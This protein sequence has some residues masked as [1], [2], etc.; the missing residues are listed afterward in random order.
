MRYERIRCNTAIAEEG[1]EHEWGASVGKISREM[2]TTG[3]KEEKYV[4]CRRDIYVHIC[5]AA[6]AGSDTRM[7]GCPMPVVINSGSGNQGMTVSIPIVIYANE[8]GISREKMY[9]A[10][11]LSNLIAINQKTKGMW[12]TDKEILQI[13]LGH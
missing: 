1:L 13:M 5:S 8:M 12:G 10:L 7:N 3:K 9:R 6:A 4:R 2:N 11:C